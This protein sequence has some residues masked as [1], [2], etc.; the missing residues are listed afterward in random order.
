[1]KKNIDIEKWRKTYYEVTADLKPYDH[2]DNGFDDAL[3]F[4]DDWINSQPCESGWI[5]V[6][7]RLPKESQSPNDRVIVALDGTGISRVLIDT[8]RIVDGKWVRWHGSVTHWMEPPL[9]PREE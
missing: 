2:Y 9:L 8:D 1:M 3:D 5:S 6:E 4:V 7:E